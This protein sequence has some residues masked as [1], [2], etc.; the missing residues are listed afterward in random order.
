M[1]RYSD[2]SYFKTA[3][4]SS[5]QEKLEKTEGDKRASKGK[6]YYVSKHLRYN[7]MIA[8][9]YLTNTHVITGTCVLAQKSGSALISGKKKVVI[10]IYSLRYQIYAQCIKWDMT[11]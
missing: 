2:P 10:C 1:R 5:E 9:N 8:L 7:N 6:V 4:A 3:W 11:L